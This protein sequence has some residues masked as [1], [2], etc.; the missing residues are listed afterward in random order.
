MDK[1][2]YQEKIVLQMLIQGHNLNEIAEWLNISRFA[3]RKIKLELFKKFKIK[4]T[5]QLLPVI[6]QLDIADKINNP[7]Q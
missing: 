2:S 7:I 5:I 4:R 3:C 6:L 1:L